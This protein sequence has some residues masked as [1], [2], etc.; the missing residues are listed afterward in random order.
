MCDFAAILGLV[1]ALTL[2]SQ[3]LLNVK[4]DSIVVR[5]DA[6]DC[7]VENGLFSR[8]GAVDFVNCQFHNVKPPMLHKNP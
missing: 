1:C 6:E 4:I 7:V 3:I 2:I 8:S 5:L